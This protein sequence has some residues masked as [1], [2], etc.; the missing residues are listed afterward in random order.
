MNSSMTHDVSGDELKTE[1]RRSG[2]A[3]KDESA[4][5]R[6][7]TKTHPPAFSAWTIGYDG[8]SAIVDRAAVSSHREKSVSALVSE[9]QYRAAAA[10]AVHSGSETDISEVIDAYNRVCA[11]NRASYKPE[12]IYRL[13]GVQRVSCERFILL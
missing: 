8:L 4:K 13:F 7:K 11:G 12:D 5:K 1:A 10:L 6:K 9:G 2:G 3:S